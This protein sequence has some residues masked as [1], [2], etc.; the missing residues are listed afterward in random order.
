MGK[1]TAYVKS[2]PWM[3]GIIVVIGAVVFFMIAS[4]GGSSSSSTTDSG[5]SDAEIAA[6]AQITAAQIAA[7]ATAA[8]YSNQLS[9]AQIGAATQSEQAQLEAAV[10]QHALDVQQT[11]G[12]AE[13]DATKATNLANIAAQQSIANTQTNAQLSA[14]KSSNKTSV[15]GSIVKGIGKIFSD[16]RLKMNITRVGTHADGYGVYEY[17]YVWG[18]ARQRGVMAQEILNIRPDAVSVH[19]SGY[20]QVD[21]SRL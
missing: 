10:A 21:Y 4:G 16:E 5:P 15:I 2:H 3:V 20:Y 19:M 13:T 14:V 1:I 12:L 17:E 11:L 8:Q 18:G 7:S 6:Q 9:M